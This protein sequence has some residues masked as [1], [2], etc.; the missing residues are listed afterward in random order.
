MHKTVFIVLIF[1][2]AISYGQSGYIRGQIEDGN[3]DA[4]LPFARVVLSSSDSTISDFDGH[5]GFLKVPEG[6]YDL[7][8]SYAGYGDTLIEN[9]EVKDKK[10][11]KLR[12]IYPPPC[13]IYKNSRKQLCPVCNKKDEVIPIIYGLPNEEMSERSDKG[14]VYLAGCMRLQSNCDPKWYC[15][16]DK[17]RF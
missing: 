5:F 11:T 2:A 7:R 4:G 3:N 15:K 9:V 13:P 6:M 1:L 10:T 17:K 8:I 16:R 12:I 14:R